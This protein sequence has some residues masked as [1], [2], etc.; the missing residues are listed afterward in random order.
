MTRLSIAYSP[1]SPILED[2]IRSAATTLI[3]RN[4]RGLLSIILEQFPEFD[5]PD[6]PDLPELPDLPDLPEIPDSINGTVIADIIKRIIRVHAYNNSE[7]LRSIYYSEEI[8]REV[9]AAVEFSDDLYG[10]FLLIRTMI[11]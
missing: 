3:T 6:L 8:T 2:V 5:F 7:S 9:I 4:L 1:E 11:I 10:M